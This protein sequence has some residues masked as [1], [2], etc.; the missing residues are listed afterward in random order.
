MLRSAFLT[1]D[2]IVAVYAKDVISQPRST[3]GRPAGGGTEVAL[4][5]LGT[6]A[7]LCDHA[8]FRDKGRVLVRLHRFHHPPPRLPLPGQRLEALDLYATAP[9]EPHLP[10]VETKQVFF[11]S[12]RRDPGTHVRP[13]STR[14]LARRRAA[15]G[16]LRLW[17][18][19]HLP[20]AGLPARGPRLGRARWRLRRGQHPGRL[21]VRGGVAPGRDAGAQTE[22]LR[23][24]IAAAEW[25]VANGYTSPRHLGIQGGSNG[26]SWRRACVTQRP[27][28]FASAVCGAPLLDMV[29]F[30][31]APN[32]QIAYG[33]LG[34][35]HVAS[36]FEYLYAYC[37]TTGW[38]RARLILRSCFRSSTPTPGSPPGTPARPAPPSSSPPPP[39]GR[40]CTGE[41]ARGPCGPV[42]DPSDRTGRRR[43][44][45][46]GR[47][48]R[49]RVIV[50][51]PEQAP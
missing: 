16:P 49:P 3:T 1:K 13:P 23:Y 4:P 2:A 24:F 25:L 9:G 6:I 15:H 48:P 41:G 7:G 21:R 11:S 40:S 36:E 14:A 12:G 38:Q 17:R 32:G 42:P 5:G 27:D 34:N 31:Q 46:P 35:P 47:K 19:G 44:L 51:S 22:R 30:D 26:G 20:G 33:E 8:R 45:L 43:H 10:A 37:H 18:L 28:L 29:R 39:T 50:P